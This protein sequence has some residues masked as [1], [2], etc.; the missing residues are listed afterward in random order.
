MAPLSILT[1]FQFLAQAEYFLLKAISEDE[2][3]KSL[4][5]DNKRVVNFIKEEALLEL[6]MQR[7]PKVEEKAQESSPSAE[8]QPAE[9]Q[10][11]KEKEAKKTPSRKPVPQLECIARLEVQGVPQKDDKVAFQID[12]SLLTNE[13]ESCDF[14][15]VEDE[16]AFNKE[17]F[18]AAHYFKAYL[19]E[20]LADHLEKA[21]ESFPTQKELKEQ[22][23][24]DLEAAIASGL[25]V[26]K[27]GQS[28]EPSESKA[29]EDAQAPQEETKD[30]KAKTPKA[31]ATKE[32]SKAAVNE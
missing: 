22:I 30:K 6:W 1:P 29:S 25:V 15:L 28:S 32:K 7:T 13:K 11:V 14:I 23:E 24:K 12:Y 27:K 19:Y 9:D 4:A 5:L 20:S 18:R 10:K 2:A 26:V 17:A 31:K 3:L 16:N 21:P 8:S